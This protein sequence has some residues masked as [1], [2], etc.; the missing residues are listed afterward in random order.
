M[1][2]WL[3][4]LAKSHGP[5]QMVAEKIALRVLA[6]TPMFIFANGWVLAHAVLDIYC[7]QDRDDVLRT[8]EMECRHVSAEHGGLSTR[9]AIDAL[10]GV[11]SAVR[12]SMRLNDVMI[13]LMPVD[14][15]AG[16][17]IDLGPDLQI[18]AG[19]DVRSVFPA[20]MVHMDPDLY[21][22]PERFDPFRFSRGFDASHPSRGGQSGAIRETTTTVG[23]SFLPFGYG[24]HACPGRWLAALM[25]KQALAHVLLK[26]D[27]KILKKPERKTSLLNFMVPPQNVEMLVT[28]K[29]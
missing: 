23:T 17:T 4:R 9:E 27:I 13:Y 2:Q 28:R 5:E 1:I 26:Y 3:I 22:S 18:A 25:V 20:Q 14:V 7:S 16:E 8:L 15:V 29:A 10:Y 21:R 11:D 6:L 24:R 19:S 12:E